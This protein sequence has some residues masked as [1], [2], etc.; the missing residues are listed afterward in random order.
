MEYAIKLADYFDENVQNEVLNSLDYPDLET[1]G[2]EW[3]DCFL[4]ERVDETAKASDAPEH[5]KRIVREVS[6]ILL[7]CQSVLR[8]ML[9]RITP[10]GQELRPYFLG[11]WLASLGE[12]YGWAESRW[13]AARLFDPL[14]S[15]I[16]W[17]TVSFLRDPYRPF[18]KPALP[19][20]SESIIR[21][22]QIYLQQSRTISITLIPQPTFFFPARADYNHSVERV[23][24]G[25]SAYESL[26]TMDELFSRID[27]ATTVRC[28]KPNGS[29]PSQDTRPG[30]PSSVVPRSPLLQDQ[31][32]A[33]HSP[34]PRDLLLIS[35]IRSL[36][37]L[38]SVQ[39][40]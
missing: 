10:N 39:C 2:L 30:F 4:E 25:F 3:L 37:R 12:R 8:T 36:R 13:R 28:S 16:E 34:S 15:L 29:F 24:K 27:L 14:L 35:K 32:D 5:E 20:P 7:T 6:R 23:D 19:L 31:S 11:A 22:R 38:R 40:L 17:A 9:S 26:S 18:P 21:L 33:Y 1:T